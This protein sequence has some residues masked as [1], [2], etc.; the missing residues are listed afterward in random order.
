VSTRVLPDDTAE[1]DSER[2]TAPAEAAAPPFEQVYRD[3]AARVYRYCLSQVSNRG[4][5]EDLA[6]DVFAAAFHAFAT[7]ELTPG[8]ELAWLLRIARNAVID[9][10]R[11]HTRRSALLARFFGG[12]TE[13]DPKAN[14]E[15]EVVLR[16]E[17]RQA[18][19]AMAHLSDKDRAV[20]GLRIAAGL[21]YAEVAAVLGVSEHAAT[22][23]CKR[24]LA[25]LQRHMGVSR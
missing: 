14:V 25:R 2:G 18:L 5:A 19:A 23:A 21:P 22:M 20:I 13:A 17:V 12:E 9:H 16:D 11:R 4:D 10:R 3:H 7:A 1:P 6:A 15:G 24:A 8:A